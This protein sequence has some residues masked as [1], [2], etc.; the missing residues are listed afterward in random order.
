MTACPYGGR[1]RAF[2]LPAAVLGALVLVGGCT[3]GDSTAA[4]GASDSPTTQLSSDAPV[5]TEQPSGTFTAT[6]SPASVSL[7]D[8]LLPTG[9]VAGL[10]AQ[11]KWQDGD[12]GQPTTDPFGAC[13]KADLLSI[14]ATEVVERTYFP[15]DDSDDNAAEQVAEFP[16][17]ATA[18][19]SWAVLKS[20]HDTCARTAAADHPGLKVGALTPVPVGAGSGRWYLL[21]WQPAGEETGRFEAFGMV[22]NGTRVVVLRIDHSGQDHDYPPGKDPMVSMVTA[23]AGWLT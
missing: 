3:H 7:L 14:G 6:G 11:W 12:T 1:M 16:D 18:A 5:P 8:R 10:N 15:P 17:P 21:S 13:A 9:D 4:R 20:W 23:A 19:R 22:L 2:P